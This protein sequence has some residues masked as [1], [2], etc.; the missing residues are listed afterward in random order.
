MVVMDESHEYYNKRIVI[1]KRVAQ[2]LQWFLIC[3]IEYH[4]Y[5]DGYALEYSKDGLLY[6]E[7]C[8]GKQIVW[9]VTL[10]GP[11]VDISLLEDVSLNLVPMEIDDQ[12]KYIE[13]HFLLKEEMDVIQLSN[14]RVIDESWIKKIS[15]KR[16]D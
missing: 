11:Y 15:P 10:L 6:V 2:H 9:N 5:I 7:D 12:S 4:K 16:R 8:I 1:F 13:F 3:L 14:G